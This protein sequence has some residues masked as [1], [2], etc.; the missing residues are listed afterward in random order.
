MTKS[1]KL[2]RIEPA[3]P[4]LI[5]QQDLEVDLM[6]T[7]GVGFLISVSRPLG[8]TVVTHIGGKGAQILRK[9]M[10]VVRIR[11]ASYHS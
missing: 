1:S 2:P 4:Y 5:K 7:A 8:M 9:A 10:Q 3:L 6:F 11:V